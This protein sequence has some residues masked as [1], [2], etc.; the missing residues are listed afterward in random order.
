L[1][2]YGSVSEALDSQTP[3]VY[4]SRPLFIEEHGL[5]LLLERDGVGVELSREDYEGGNWATAVERAWNSGSEAK[6]LKRLEGETGKRQEQVKEMGR[7]VV[8]WIVDWKW[9]CAE[10]GD[11]EV[12]MH[13]G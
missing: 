12:E 11:D 6:R 2:G 8:D 7:R 1:Q 10:Q 9:K 3:F 4:V 13:V 5:R